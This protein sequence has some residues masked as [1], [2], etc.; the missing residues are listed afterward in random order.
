MANRKS[1]DI[2]TLPLLWIVLAVL[3]WTHHQ[4]LQSP[5]NTRDDDFESIIAASRRLEATSTTKSTREGGLESITA[6]SGRLEATSTI[7]R[8]DECELSPARYSNAPI[9]PVL[10]ASYP[11]SGTQMTRILISQL[12]HIQT[13]SMW[14]PSDNRDR[15]VAIKTHYPFSGADEYFALTEEIQ[16][17]NRAIL[18]LRSP[19]QA[20]PSFFNQL[21]ERK[22]NLVRRRIG[23][24]FFFQDWH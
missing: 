7:E 8:D 4:F 16:F 12:T 10:L 13:K 2:P 24:P 22:H 14:D 21:H 11:G 20:I 1:S 3:L 15:A 17:E 6:T 19:L 18:I 23:I 9:R 5:V